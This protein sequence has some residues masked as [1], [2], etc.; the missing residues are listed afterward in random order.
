MK[1]DKELE[2]L[3][4]PIIDIYNKI[5]LE[6]L[7]NIAKRFSGYQE[8]GITGSLE[9][10]NTKLDELGGLNAD[11][12]N[13]ISEYAGIT[14]KE[15]YKMLEEAGYAN[16]D[17][18]VINTAYDVGL[19]NVNYDN[20]IKSKVFS[21]VINNSY[22]ELNET[23]RLINTKA[24]EATKQ[25]YMNV[26][27]RS[28]LEVSSGIYDYNT[29]IRKAIEQMVNNGITCATYKRK[30]GKIVNYSIEGVVRR[31]TMTAVFQASNKSV[32]GLSEII[33]SDYVEVSSHYNARTSDRSEIANHA[34]W[35]G[36][37]YKLHGFDENYGNF[38]AHCGEGDIE[39]FGGINC[40]HRKCSFI[41]GISKPTSIQYD[42]NEVK[43]AYELSQ[44]Q[45][46][47]ERQVRKEKQHVEVAK[48]L[49]DEEY[50]K[51]HQSKLKQKQ[52]NLK[53]FCEENDLKRDYTREFVDSKSDNKIFSEDINDIDVPDFMKKVDIKSEAL[54]VFPKHIQ[55]VCKDV[56]IE[57]I[58]EKYSYYSTRYDKIFISNKANK[59]D[60]I[61]EYGHKIERTLNLYENKEF[62][63]LLEEKFSKYKKADFK[64]IQSKTGK[65]YILN[66]IDNFVSKY[67]TRI[68]NNGFSF[69]GNIKIK[70][71]KEYFTEGLKYYF[72]DIDLLKKKDIDLYEFIRKIMEDVNE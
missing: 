40:K 16:I 22:K 42:Y 8:T 28:Y 59:Y 47:L 7:M 55:N 68:Y 54:M 24:I 4:Q 64:V 56:P 60:L 61:H 37:I 39:G 45:R 43:K 72:K 51:K 53:F 48:S 41:P 65:Y 70:Y 19:A 5:E 46:Y 35:Q 36:K 9:W 6:L 20:L 25:A 57:Q 32:D 15:I 71:A 30:N 34:G 62:I 31:D 26:L 49:G 1:T 11:A 58:K 29:S 69:L 2:L 21:Q 23:F 3:V 44:K 13:T 38:Y 18:R 63:K 27:N 67:Q 12:V 52:F 14:K 33:G 66:D 50:L 10:Y 17:K